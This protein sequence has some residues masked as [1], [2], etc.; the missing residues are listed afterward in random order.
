L[1][2]VGGQVDVCKIE[3]ENISAKDVKFL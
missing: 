2:I 3:P 1:N